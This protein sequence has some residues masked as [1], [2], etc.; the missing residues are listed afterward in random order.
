MKAMNSQKMAPPPLARRR[1]TVCGCCGRSCSVTLRP[2]RDAADDALHAGG[3]PA[4]VVALTERGQ[5]IFVARLAG[6]AVGDELFELVADLHLH[7]AVLHGHHDEQAVVAPFS[8]M[9][10]P[11][12]WNIF[13]AYSSIVA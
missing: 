4:A 2:L 12:F 7:P 6:K 9:P 8:P 13:T 5:Q 3:E 11:P 1:R 10:R